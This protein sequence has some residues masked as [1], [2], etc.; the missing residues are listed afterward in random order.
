MREGTAVEAMGRYGP[1]IRYTLGGNT[2]I[3]AGSGRNAGKIITTY[4]SAADEM[5]IPFK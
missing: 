1:Q 5:F 3:V 4:S 2:V